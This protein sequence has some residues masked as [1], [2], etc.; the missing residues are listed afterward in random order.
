MIIYLM[1]LIDIWWII[2]QD[3][4]KSFFV[5]EKETDIQCC[6]HF[7]LISFSMWV[8]HQVLR[9]TFVS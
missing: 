3:A 1:D 5:E 9:L 7:L 4:I 6:L 8:F 2:N